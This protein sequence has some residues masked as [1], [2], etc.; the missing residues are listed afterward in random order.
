MVV[1]WNSLG[2]KLELILPGGNVEFT[3]FPDATH[4]SWS[5]AYNE[6]DLLKWFLKYK[7]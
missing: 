6:T 7:K 2:D 1:M 5:Q 3:V 4:N